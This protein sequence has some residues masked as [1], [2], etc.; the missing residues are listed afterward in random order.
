MPT[1]PGER[2]RY[3]GKLESAAKQ[4]KRK[5]DALSAKPEVAAA[6]LGISVQE[7]TAL[8]YLPLVVTA[9]NYGFS[10]RVADVLVAEAE[11]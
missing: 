1:E 3:D 7:A 8:Q 4:A 6:A 11:F 5:A 2:V 10:T 9:Q